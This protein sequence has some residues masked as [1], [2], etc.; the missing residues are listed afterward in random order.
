M[1]AVLC[2]AWIYIT[3]TSSAFLWLEVDLWLYRFSAGSF[4]Y[5]FEFV[6]HPGGICPGCPVTCKCNLYV[7]IRLIDFSFAIGTFA[8]FICVQ[9]LPVLFETTPEEE[10][11]DLI[12]QIQETGGLV[13]ARKSLSLL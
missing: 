8:E 11:R 4:S 1:L 10:F 2:I 9:P 12:T 3:S 7:G 6:D 5:G 13:I